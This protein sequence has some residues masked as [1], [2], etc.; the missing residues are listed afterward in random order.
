LK[1]QISAGPAPGHYKVEDSYRSSQLT[2]KAF[3]I[4][5]TK[6]I[7]VADHLTNEKKYVPAVGSY[8]TEGAYEKAT[9]GLA[10]GW[11]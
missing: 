11:K 5:K 3:V 1:L 8:N 10:K 9:R 7:G 6:L 4:S 2:E